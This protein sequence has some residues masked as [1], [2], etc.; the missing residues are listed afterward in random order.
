MEKRVDRVLHDNRI[1]GIAH[2]FEITFP[3][4]KTFIKK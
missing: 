2:I 4:G 1:S 3:L